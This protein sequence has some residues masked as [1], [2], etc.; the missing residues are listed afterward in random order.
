MIKEIFLNLAV[1]DLAASM[2]FFKKLG[3]EF[4]PQ[5]TNEKAACLI[6]GPSMY[7]MLLTEPFF[8]TFTTKSLV[9]AKESAQMMVAVTLETKQKVDEMIATAFAAG[10]DKGNPDQDYGW[11]YSR[12]FADLDGH[13]W[14]VLFTDEEALK[15]QQAQ[16]G[17]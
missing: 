7:A 4:N 8:Q 14:E 13:I 17:G 2:A 3:F 10:A 15:K 1:K 5:F 12:S 11:M 6:L 16:S 9:N